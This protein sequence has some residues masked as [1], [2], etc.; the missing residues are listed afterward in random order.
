MRHRKTKKTVEP[1]TSSASDSPEITMPNFGSKKMNE[2]LMGSGNLKVFPVAMSLIASFISGVAILG[3]PAEIYNYGTQYFLIIV[4]ISIQGLVVAYVYMPVFSA[5]QVRSSYE[6]LGMRFHPIIRNIVSIMFVIEVLL[7]TPFVVYV[8]ALALNQASGLDIHMIELVTIVVCVIYTLLGGLKAVVHTD[9]WQVAIMFVSVLVVAILATCNITDMGEFFESLAAGGRLIIGNTDPSPFVRNTVW[10]VLIGGSFYW[11]SIAAVHQTMV[12]RYMS[13]PNLRMVRFSIA[14]FVVGA[15]IFYTVLSFLGLLIYHMYKD[16]DPLSAGHIMN[17]DQLVPLFVV[18][19]VG[20]IYGMPGLFIAGLFGAGLSSLSVAFNSTSLVILQDIVRGCFKMQPGER[21]S[22]IIVKS[23]IVI[24]G[25]VI[26]GSVI[27]L[28]KVNGILSICMSLVSIATSS[29]FGMFT[30]GM[31]VPWANTVGTLVGGIASFSLTAWITFGT[32]IAAASG[33]LLTH[34]LPMSLEGCPGNVT[35][36]EDVGVD[37]EQVFPLYR[38]SFQWINPIGVLT[39]VIVGSLVS[40]VTRPTDIKSLHSDL[41]SPVIHRF[42]PK[43]CFKQRNLHKN[44]G[45]DIST[46]T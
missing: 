6:Y 38:L 44:A 42:L 21:T 5:L 43:E 9:I 7:Y 11:T 14:Y 36:P 2:Y 8:P 26:F 18:Q 3:T 46:I 10:S 41:I 13:L 12:H 16:C 39:V 28:E 34:K 20:H 45:N 30:L 19:S 31:L 35:A 27:L 33:Q 1:E 32:Q 22:T 17:N 4:A 37:E 29:T 40:L 15:V 25:V 23:T 24:M